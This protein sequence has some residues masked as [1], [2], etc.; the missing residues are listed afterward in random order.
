MNQDQGRLGGYRRVRHLVFLQTSGV[1]VFSARL[2][3]LHHVEAGQVG[4]H[5]PDLVVGLLA[6]VA[7]V[8]LCKRFFS[9]EG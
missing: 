6:D 3:H 2:A 1:D 5:V 7:D 8:D 9:G 4:A